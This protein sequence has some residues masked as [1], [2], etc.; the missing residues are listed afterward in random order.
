MLCLLC[1]LGCSSLAAFAQK[2]VSGTVVDDKGEAVIGANVVEKGTTNGVITDIDGKFSLNVSGSNSVLQISFVGYVTQEIAVGNQT[3]LQIVLKE[4]SETLEE[5]V[6][7]GYGIQ[8]KTHLLGAV[9][10]VQASEVE[11]ISTGRLTNALSGR[12]AGV[13]IAQGSGGRPGNTSDIT[14]RARGTWNSTAPLFVIDGVARDQRIFDNLDPSMVENISVLKDASAASIYGSR[15]ANG[16]VLVTTKRGKEGG[17]P[18]INYTGSLGVGG[19]A[20]IPKRESMEQRFQMINNHIIEY[21]DTFFKE[22]AKSSIYANGVDASGGYIGSQVLTDDEMAMYRARGEVDMLKEAYQTPIT[23]NNAINISGGNESIKYFTGA[24]YYDESGVFQTLKYT[25]YNIRGNVEAKLNKYWTAGLDINT[26]YAQEKSPYESSSSYNRGDD[27]LRWLWG[28][29]MRSSRLIRPKIGDK[30]TQVQ[31]GNWGSWNPVAIAEGA[32]GD[33]T[34]TNWDTEYTASL[35]WDVPW[36]EGLSAKAYFNQRWSHQHD[37]TWATPFKEYRV[38]MQGTNGHFQSDEIDS[39]AGTYGGNGGKPYL[40]ETSTRWNTYQLNAMLTYDRT[41][42]DHEISALLGYEQAQEL[43]DYFNASK[44]FYTINKPY[45]NWGPADV[46]N[47]GAAGGNYGISGIASESARLSYIGRLSYAYTGKYLAEFSFRRDASIKFHP[48]YRW[49]FFPS[50]S[51]AWR[52]GE[53]SFIKDNIAWISNMKLRGSIGLTGNDGGDSMAAWQWQDKMDPNVGGYYWGGTAITQGVTLGALANPYITWEKSLNYNAGL[54]MGFLQNMFT[55]GFDYFF[56]HTYD[57]LGSQ[58][59]EIPDT[60]GGTLATSNYGVVDSYGIELEIGYNKQINK[61]L[62]VYARGN[63][64]WADNKL[65]EYAESGVAAHL[66]KLGK[67]W[68]RRVGYITDGIIWSMDDIGNNMY[69]I[70]TSTGN[71]YVVPGNGYLNIGNGSRND[72][73]ANDF[74]AMRPGLLF[75]PDMGSISGTDANGNPIYSDE[76][77]GTVSNDDADK[78]WIINHYN[79]P[80]NYGLLLGGTWKG[81]SLEVFINGFAGHQTFLTMDGIGGDGTIYDT[82][83]DFW[84]S[85]AYSTFNN[86]TGK[87]PAPT[88]WWGL[89]VRGTDN[90]YASNNPSFWVRDASF[91]RLKNVTLGYDLPKQLLSKIGVTGLH[92]YLTGDNVALL[93]NP[94]K[95][96]DPELAG[97]MNSLSASSTDSPESPLLSYPL[98]RTWTFGINLTF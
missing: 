96:A 23:T 69:R 81:F 90:A 16:V 2:S 80:F 92:L 9:S 63:F 60:F 88:N 51:L 77:D 27:K 30:Y 22:N 1:I 35:K 38:K 74:L 84:A 72:I 15:A 67:N 83:F 18:V 28:S 29:F 7:V 61:D 36:V 34:Q 46:N 59:A 75:Y 93:Y 20:K 39:E 82:T 50:G 53:E 25:K 47:S 49:G 68:D 87:M 52:V 26:T 85:D 54:E 42:G 89:N 48:D 66:S 31:I 13:S 94:L 58:T 10:Q 24:S 43:S 95:V 45:F 56:R 70:H 55:F 79:P 97:S 37:K 76:K 71:E 65:V 41:F 12:V 11:K 40:S 64:G 33:I 17:K 19:F 62:S 57:I 98:M 91:V 86:P 3:S 4:D 78:R 14:V 6:V 44:N 21:G 5:V 8:K 32:A 73:T